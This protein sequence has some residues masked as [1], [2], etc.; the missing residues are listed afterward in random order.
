MAEIERTFSSIL[1]KWHGQDIVVLLGDDRLVASGYS[2]TLGLVKQTPIDLTTMRGWNSIKKVLDKNMGAA[3]CLK[4]VAAYKRNERKMRWGEIIKKKRDGSFYVEIEIE[5][6]NPLIA[7]CS[8]N[9]IGIHEQ[10][11]LQ[12]GERRA[13]HL[14][15]ID[16]VYLHNTPRVKISVDRVSKTLVEELL[17]HQLRDDQIKIRCLNR[18]VG[19]KSFVESNVF[20]PKKVILATSRELSEHIQVK[21]VKTARGC[22][23]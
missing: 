16:P 22:R 8:R 21:V 9:H 10:D 23:Y 1:S 7:A 11:H 12:V 17:K 2:T 3:A 4:E 6:G 13:F 14:R 18:Y 19:H 20:L 15:R 5:S